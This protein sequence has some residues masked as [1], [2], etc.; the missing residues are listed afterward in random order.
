MTY[1]HVLVQT[2]LHNQVK[3]HAALLNQTI[4]QYTESAL[5]RQLESFSLPGAVEESTEPHHVSTSKEPA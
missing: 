4:K 2:D 5:R 1:K 3:A